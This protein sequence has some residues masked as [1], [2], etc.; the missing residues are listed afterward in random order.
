MTARGEPPVRPMSGVDCAWLRMDEPTNLMIING[1]MMFDA[2]L[3]PHRLTGMIRQRLARIP[4]FRDR[5]VQRGRIRWGWRRDENFDVDRH[6]VEEELPEPGGDRELEELV[7]GHMNEA[8]PFDRPLWR[9]HL[10]HGYG[11]GSALLW[12]LHHCI[13]DGIALMVLL[14]ALADLEPDADLRTDG[15]GLWGNDNPLSELFG[16][17]PLEPE[18]AYEHLEELLPQ[19]ARLLTKP[20]EVLGSVHPWM[21][22]LAAV[23]AFLKLALRPRDTRTPL[24]G[25][26]SRG[27][28]VAWSRGIPLE[29]I[30]IARQRLGG[31]VNDVL[32][33]AFSGGARRYLRDEGFDVEDLNFRAVV[34]VS[35]RPV[36]EMA[37]LGNEFGLVFLSLPVGIR[38]PGERLHELQRRMGKLKRS[39]EPWVVLKLLGIIGCLP[40]F[41]QDLV[42]RIF[43][44]KGTAVVT[45][46]PGP[47]RQL[48]MAGQPIRDFVFWVPQSGR[49]GMGVST[50]SYA[51]E[52]RLGVATDVDLVSEP[53]RIVAGFE[54]ELEEMIAG[55]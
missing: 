19:G 13:G 37:E 53:A 42:V 11:G 49:L 10:I 29:T 54:E 23:P 45:T 24:R 20:A 30:Q 22:R 51:G 34:P 50:M 25:P 26:L 31:T 1:I 14:L 35:L 4:R 6:L 12:R 52:V 38:D 15:G 33:T 3:D 8:L 21:L 36:E 41:L 47:T 5:A 46:V 16:E 43:G 9:I 55:S 48:Y 32:L 17:E 39:V 40:R 7:S 44:S 2:P 18:E 27:K 28:R